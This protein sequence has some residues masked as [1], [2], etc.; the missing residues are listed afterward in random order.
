LRVSPFADVRALWQCDRLLRAFP[1]QTVL[2]SNASYSTWNSR[3]ADTAELIPSCVF[4]PLA[5]EDVSFA[6]KTLAKPVGNSKNHYCPF[7]IKGGGHTPWA[8]ANNVDG[9][10]AIDLTYLNQTTLTADRSVISL[11]GGTIWHDAYSNMDGQGVAF[12][13]GRCPG[14]GVG[15]K[16]KPTFRLPTRLTLFPV[17]RRHLG[18]RL[19]VCLSAVPRLSAWA[20]PSQVVHRPD[21]LCG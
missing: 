2:A 7:S 11:G 9:G 3:W 17:Y 5:V 13:G 19:L 14:T 1:D 15:G 12:P 20:N 8:G 10:V 16:H 6:V 18:R 4:R 21:W